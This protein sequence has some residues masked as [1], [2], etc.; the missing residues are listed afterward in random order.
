LGNYFF[1]FLI[2]LLCGKTQITDSQSGFRV[3]QADKMQYIEL[4]NDFTNRQEMILKAC[5]LGLKI[6]EVPIAIKPRKFGSSFLGTIK[7]KVK[8]FLVVFKV[9][10]TTI[11]PENL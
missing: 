6:K 7:N 8:F 10:L 4:E 3:I 5:R 1:S 2:S 9:I 11:K